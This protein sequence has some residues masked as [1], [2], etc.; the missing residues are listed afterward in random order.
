MNTTDK[1]NSER[2]WRSRPSNRTMSRRYARA[3][4]ILSLLSFELTIV[5]Y[6]VAKSGVRKS[7]LY[8]VALLVYSVLA[9]FSIK[10]S[11]TG[12]IATYL[13]IAFVLM[14][15]AN[16]L[17]VGIF[18]APVEQLAFKIISILLGAYFICCGI[19]LIVEEKRLRKPYESI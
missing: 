13:I 5:I 9:L 8:L 1:T 11:K 10:G 7:I 18:I 16:C 19:M 3:V 4:V 2:L 12:R 14:T 17:F 15:A 6:S